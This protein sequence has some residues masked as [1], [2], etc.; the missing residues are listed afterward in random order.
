[1]FDAP[2]LLSLTFL[3]F[4][5]FPDGHI[6][7]LL[8][9]QVHYLLR[10]VAGFSYTEPSEHSRTVT[11]HSIWSLTEVRLKSRNILSRWF[12]CFV[13]LLRRQSQRR[14]T[15]PSG[16]RTW[17]LTDAWTDLPL[18]SLVPT[19]TCRLFRHPQSQS[20]A[21]VNYL[22]SSMKAAYLLRCWQISTHKLPHRFADLPKQKWSKILFSHENLRTHQQICLHIYR[23]MLTF[24]IFSASLQKYIHTFTDWSTYLKISIHLQI[25]VDI[26]YTFA[27][28]IIHTD[29]D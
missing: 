12:S 8:Q 27:N 18:A 24:T 22:S 2:L 6:D 15:S 29:F 9:Q 26:F 3:W 13:R 21:A 14:R 4:L 28:V 20:L 5:D 10:A 11:K 25:L 17:A 23:S 16:L 19:W 7:L 1:M